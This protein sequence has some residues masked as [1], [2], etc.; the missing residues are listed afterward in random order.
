MPSVIQRHPITNRIIAELEELDFPVGDN[1]NP[2]EA[3]GWSGE[4]NESSS[5]F[6]PWMIV[7]ALTGTPQ[8][9]QAFGD[10]AR[11]W[12]L[13]YSIFFAGVSRAQAERLADRMRQKLVNIERDSITTENGS[14]RIQKISYNS[15]GNSAKVTSAYP[16]Y[17]TQT[18]TFEV[19]V[20]KER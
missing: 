3:Y 9:T 5:S 2:T 7:T 4:P 6:M 15:V 10:S 1:D 13:P 14:W 16:D 17:Y 18:D 19:W 11:E 12:L 20:S 8:R